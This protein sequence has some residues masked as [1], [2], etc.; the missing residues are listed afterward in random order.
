MSTYEISNGVIILS[1]PNNFQFH[2]YTELSYR[3]PVGKQTYYG[4]PIEYL[5]VNFLEDVGVNDRLPKNFLMVALM[6]FS[7]ISV[8]LVHTAFL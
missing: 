8:L 1:N 5:Y 2:I 3:F 4:K 7:L 6:P